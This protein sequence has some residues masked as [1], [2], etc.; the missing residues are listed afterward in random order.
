MLNLTDPIQLEPIVLSKAQVD[1]FSR[2]VRDAGQDPLSG[3]ARQVAGEVG[4]RFPEGF[5]TFDNLIKGTSSFY[6]LNPETKDLDPAERRLT[7]EDII[8]LFV[9]DP[10]G[11]KLVGDEGA[12][13][14]EGLKREAAPQIFSLTGA[15]GGARAGA[16]IPLPH[17]AAKLVSSLVLGVGGGFLGYKGGSE[18]SDY[19]LGTERV[20]LPGEAKAY[21]A[22]KTAG[23]ALAWLPLPFLIPKNANLGV[24]AYLNN[25]SKPKGPFSSHINLL[26]GTEPADRSRSVR[27]AA[28]IESMLGK[29][30]TGAFAAPKT[31]AGAEILA[32]TGQ[33]VGAYRAEEDAPSSVSRRI[34]YE[35]L[36]GLTP[37]AAVGIVQ[38][39]PTAQ[40]FGGIRNIFRKVREE[41]LRE[42][43]KDVVG[44]LDVVKRRRQNK[45]VQR[46]MDILEAEGEDL[47]AVIERLASDEVSSLLLDT[48]TG[49]PIIQTAGTK[50]GSPT[51]LAIEASL[52]NMGSA[53]GKEARSGK[54]ASFKALRNLIVGLSTTGDQDALKAAADMIADVFEGGLTARL[55]ESTSGVLR[56]FERIRGFSPQSNLALSERLFDTI[57]ANIG[58]AR[59]Q[60][61]KL[62]TAVPVVNVPVDV[63]DPPKFL[64]YWSG[65]DGMTKEYR[66]QSIEGLARLQ[67]FVSRKKNELGFDVDAQGNPIPPSSD[68]TTKELSEMRSAALQAGRELASQGKSN[69][70]RIAFEMADALLDDLDSI[71]SKGG[72]GDL[73]L[74][75]FTMA[76]DS[77]RAYSRALNDTFTRAFAGEAMSTVKTG[78]ERI[79]PE[80]LARRTLQGGADPTYLRLA[81]IN[82]IGK[83]AIEQGLEGAQETAGTLNGVTEAIL[84]NA[85][86][87]AFD[88][89]SGT[90]SLRTL[91]R[92]VNENKELLDSFPTIRDDLLDS[93]KA[94]VL[95]DETSEINKRLRQEALNEV[96]FYNLINPRTPEG[97]ARMRGAESA[98]MAIAEALRSK[99]PARALNRLLKVAKSEELGEQGQIDAL[100]GL[101]SA[102]LEH[103]LTRAGASETGTFRPS[104][105]YKAIFEPMSTAQGRVSMVD[106]MTSNGVMNSAESKN[107]KNIMEEMLKLEI[108]TA[109]GTVDQ[110]VEQVGPVFDMYLAI[111]GSAIGTKI[112]RT[113]T[114]GQSGPGALVAAGKGAEAMRKLFSNIPA[115]LQTDVISELM[116]D[117]KLLAAMMRKPRNDNEKLG[118][119]N[120]LRKILEGKG[121]VAP[122]SPVQRVAPPVLRESIRESE[123]YDPVEEQAP[124]PQVPGYG[125]GPMF[126]PAST[127]DQRSSVRPPAVPTRSVAAAQQPPI[128]PRPAPTPAPQSVASAPTQAPASPETRQR[129]AALFPNDPASSMIRSQQG[130]GGLLG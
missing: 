128:P 111:T 66:E 59:N 25:L 129:Y 5:V 71:G 55:Q 73:F 22:G 92:W 37:A 19:L 81:Q 72:Q 78:A 47:D 130:I 87:A 36:G 30:R 9:R 68:L 120:Y 45:G 67:S 6:D 90:M 116:R 57:E 8:R 17:P 98:S 112:Q 79:A 117:P 64:E 126:T 76:Y 121:F 43:T 124:T 39:S 40:V 110:L 115:G 31:V 28:A 52:E 95:L 61:R 12:T 102:I 46:I 125:Y 63:S 26:K 88:P 122:L 93:E 58:F 18:F 65:L 91:R 13:F 20:I 51:L 106:W 104:E 44:S 70:A 69:N 85:R 118:L 54:E 14:F 105:F 97:S 80:L 99:A 94:I 56:A 1:E 4:G 74:D 100:G 42:S 49:K 38:R 23:G 15:I 75:Q 48:E 10:E 60:E 107:L 32:G 21:E 29:T 86:A 34:T 83:F 101:K 103:A 89:D 114:G 109:D 24:A 108:A 35:I 27:V 41:G 16:K 127:P 77:A 119:A 11:R 84:R 50:T 113:M 2:V 62:W 96:S 7:S 33:A 53:I 82:D 3:L 123:D